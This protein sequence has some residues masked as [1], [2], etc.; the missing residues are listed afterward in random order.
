M[1]P[2]GLLFMAAGVFAAIGSIFD[3][4]FFM[5]ARKARFIVAVLTRIGARAFYGALGVALL[6][7]GAV[8]AS[9]AINLTAK[10]AGG[11]LGPRGQ[12]RVVENTVCPPSYRMLAR[13]LG[14]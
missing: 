10:T 3:W 5:I 8:A 1:N 12:T 6:T 2:P 13:S 4:D 11:S 9:G 14:R 7:H